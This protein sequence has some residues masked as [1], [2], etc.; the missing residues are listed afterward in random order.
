MKT[1]RKSSSM[2][3]WA[4]FEPHATGPYAFFI[5]RAGRAAPSFAGCSPSRQLVVDS[6]G[7]ARCWQDGAWRSV[8]GDPVEA[9]AQFVAAS[10]AEPVDA[11]S[12]LRGR[13]LPRT[14]G[15]LSYELATFIDRM[16]AAPVDFLAAPLAVLSTYDSICAWSPRDFSIA[17]V[18]FAGERSR[19]VPVE[20]RGSP[21]SGW[22]Q[23][24]R[25]LYDEGFHTIQEAIAAGDLYQAN[26]SRRALFDV[27]E[28]ACD[29]YR[30]MRAVQ[31]VP[32]GAFLDCGGF[33]LLSNSPECF[34][35]RRSDAV[36]TL[37]IKGTR[38][39]RR[40]HAADMSMR[41]ELARDAKE[42]AEHLMIVD[43]ERND[44][45]RVACTGSV[46]VRDYATVRT[47]ATVHHMVSQVRARLRPR[48]GLAAL[49]RATFPGG[50]IT[51][52]PKIA[53][54]DLL[55]RVERYTRGPY[56]GAIGMFNGEDCLEM[57]IAIRTAVVRDGRACYS[58]G[59][60]IVADSDL[61]R[62]WT[63]TETKIAA[64]RCSLRSGS[65]EAVA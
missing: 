29:L 49:L 21:A 16:K 22:R 56:T 31:P 53:A 34:L 60:G 64:F 63:E 47:Y 42:R 2:A 28:P 62:E 4:L 43:L 10:R 18:R 7:R 3:T 25:A 30:R 5:D 58:A 35:E 51:G 55:A 33:H 41:A 12:W 20:L 11:P 17:R 48:T 13:L 27:N 24:D 57:S 61:Q 14:V 36:R 65:T 15:Y 45:G 50:S 26:L 8:D 37:P 40:D 19:P 39:R 9:I 59:G 54:T 23:T 52:A 46:R 1:L 44:L 38:P 32:Y 6:D